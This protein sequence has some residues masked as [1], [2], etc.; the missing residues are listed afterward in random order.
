M[1]YL[2]PT[3]KIEMGTIIQSYVTTN[4]IEHGLQSSRNVAELVWRG[5]IFDIDR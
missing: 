2:H 1:S 5:N 4:D 3:R